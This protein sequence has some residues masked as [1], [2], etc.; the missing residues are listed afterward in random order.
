MAVK[1]K[2][3]ALYKTV[4]SGVMIAL[5]LT[6]PFL[7]AQIPEIGNAFLP[8]HLPVLLCGL[9][10]GWQWGLT[11][12]ALTP[13]LRS[14]IFSAPILYPRAVAMSAELA[15]YGAISGLVFLLITKILS[16]S[17]RKYTASLYISLVTAMLMGR[18]VWG[19]VQCL[20]LGVGDGGFTPAAFVGGAFLEAVPGIIIQL[21]VIPPT[22]IIL[23][24]A[25]L[26]PGHKIYRT[27]SANCKDSEKK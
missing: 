6:L 8:M 13:I 18:A 17:I 10:C 1:K 9:V 2:R 22:V 24:H 21:L 23:I 4:L 25:G 15:T 19:I 14:L 16:G 26:V 20:L 11:V 27:S 5:G 12:G 3:D 7:T